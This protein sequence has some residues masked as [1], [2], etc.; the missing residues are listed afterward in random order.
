MEMT[1]IL[2]MKIGRTETITINNINYTARLAMSKDGQE[3]TIFVTND[4]NGKQKPYHIKKEYAEDLNSNNNDFFKGELK[5]TIEADI[6]N[7]TL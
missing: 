7:G 6:Q 4:D 3:Y 5:K 1:M 2:G